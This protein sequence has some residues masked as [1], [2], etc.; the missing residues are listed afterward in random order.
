M[1]PRGLDETGRVRGVLPSLRRGVRENRLPPQQ[2]RDRRRRRRSPSPPGG[3]VRSHTQRELEGMPLVVPGR[4]YDHE[5]AR[6]RQ[7]RQCVLARGY[8]LHAAH[9]VQGFEG[10]HECTGSDAGDVQRGSRNPSQYD[11]TRV[12]GHSDGHRGHGSDAAHVSE[13]LR[14]RR[15]RE[16]PLRRK[17]GTAWD[18]AYASLFLHSDEAGFITG[19]VLPVDGGQAAR[20]G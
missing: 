13:E 16:V 15:D 1:R 7:H 19:V 10:R 4:A 20:I 14:E 11:R 18:V 5:R 8:R 2:R 6:Q 12:D 9:G 3:G 17:M